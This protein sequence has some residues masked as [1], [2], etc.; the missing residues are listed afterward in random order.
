M[1]WR[2]VASV[3]GALALLNGAWL[4]PA[5]AS[6]FPPIDLRDEAIDVV[7]SG[8]STLVGP[9]FGGS[10]DRVYFGAVA[11]GAFQHVAWPL[12]SAGLDADFQL[13][14]TGVRGSLVLP[15]QPAGLRLALVQSVG[16][17]RP[18]SMLGFQVPE[19]YFTHGAVA[20]AWRP[21]SGEGWH[22]GLRAMV[23]PLAG[24]SPPGAA[25]PGFT[26][27]IV[28]SAELAFGWGEGLELVFGGNNLVGARAAF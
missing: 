28:P 17:M 22:V 24:W 8:G 26:F 10:I 16:W 27:A 14:A 20:L 15:W 21:W 11:L 9:L 25:Q 19:R 3:A 1:A 5:Q 12:A 6:T 7:Y 4:G 2:R 18:F 23:G 13:L